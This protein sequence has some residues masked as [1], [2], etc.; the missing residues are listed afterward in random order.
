M[1]VRTKN[2]QMSN[3]VH[4]EAEQILLCF[5]ICMLWYGLAVAM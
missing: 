1:E 3:N 4:Q 2:E 5:D